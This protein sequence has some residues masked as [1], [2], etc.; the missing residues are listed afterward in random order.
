MSD[1][2]CCGC[3]VTKPLL[4]DMACFYQYLCPLCVLL[5]VLVSCCQCLPWKITACHSQCRHTYSFLHST[6]AIFL[7]S[8]YVSIVCI[9]KQSYFYTA[10]V[11]LLFDQKDGNAKTCFMN[12][13]NTISRCRGS[14]SGHDPSISKTPRHETSHNYDRTTAEEHSRL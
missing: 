10:S 3:I 7:F 1:T 4:R 14:N 5:E 2:H 6:P 13:G 8:S 12:P 11:L 9:R